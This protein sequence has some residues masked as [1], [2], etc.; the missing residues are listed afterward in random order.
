MILT[1][2]RRVEKEMM[3]TDK[4]FEEEV[5]KSEIPVLV[6]FWGSWCPPC[7]AEKKVLKRLEEEYAGKIKI[8]TLN[9]NRNPR[10]TL[11]YGI[12]GVP[13]FII[14]HNGKII[15]RDIAAKSEKQLRKMIEEALK[16]I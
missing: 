9:V 11:R 16:K 4:N 8:G 14:F 6:E 5:L 12:K 7:Q 15:H 13:T 1:R 2:S 10:T 3:L